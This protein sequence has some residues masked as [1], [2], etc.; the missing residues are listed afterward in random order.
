MNETSSKQHYAEDSDML[1]E[2]D[3]TGGVRGK[4]HQAYRSG[5]TVTIHQTD[6]TKIVQ[7]F[8]LEEGAVMLAPDVREYFPDEEAVNNALRALI[9]LI[10]KKRSAVITE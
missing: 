1:P 5:H 7:Q 4:H 9:S 10:P 8:K 6:G 2:Y 3:F